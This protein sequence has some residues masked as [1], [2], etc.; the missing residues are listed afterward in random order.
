MASKH[1]THYDPFYDEDGDEFGYC[2]TELYDGN[3][4]GNKDL[5]SCKKCIKKFDQADIEKN[6]AIEQNY[7]DMDGFVD[8]MFEQRYNCECGFKGCMD[9]LTY[10]QIEETYEAIWKCPDCGD[11]L[12][13][14]K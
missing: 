6:Q 8:F 13:R 10:G 2:G 7:N 4:T 3:V 12:D 11:I 14:Q 5:V 9:Q 1:V